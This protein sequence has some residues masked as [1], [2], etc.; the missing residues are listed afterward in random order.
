MLYFKWIGTIGGLLM[1]AAALW[2]LVAPGRYKET[3]LKLIPETKPSWMNP[4]GAGTAAWVIVTWLVY[5]TVPS[6]LTFYITLVAS[7][8]LVKI[9]MIFFRY[10]QFRGMVIKTMN[11]DQAIL[12]L[13][14][15]FYL[16]LGG[17]FLAI[18]AAL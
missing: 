17:A 4:V 8:S 13:L 16:M 14:S 15:L 3:A 5:L 11:A 2:I 9:Y 18:A 1:A 12:W 7:L 6:P 10:D